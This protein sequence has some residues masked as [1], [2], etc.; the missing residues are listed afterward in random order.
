MV[1]P[2]NVAQLL[3]DLVAIPSVNP[4][5]DPGTEQTG[6][7]ALG[8]YVADFLRAL[9]AEVTLDPVEPGRPNVIA[10][11]IPDKPVAHLAFAPHL[12]TVSVAGMTIPPFDPVIRDGK[13][14]GRGSTDTKGPMAAAL[15]AV[16]AWAQSGAREK[17][18]LRLSFLA[19]MGEEAGNDGAHAL[20]RKGFSS[21]LTLVL[22]PTRLGVVTAHKGALWLEINTT[23]VACH[24]AT[25][26]QGRNAIYAMRRALEIIEEKII[27]GFSRHPHP[28]L[29]PVTLN[30]GTISGGSKINIVPDRCRAEIDCRIV[31]GI[32]TETFSRRLE[33]DLRA[34]APGVTVRLQRHSPPLETDESLPWVRR[35]GEQARGFAA[36]PW[37]SDASVLSGPQCPAIC[38]GPGSIAQAHTK[39]EFILL[40]DLEEG[41]EFFHRWM[42][43][44][45]EFSHER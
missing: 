18:R 5:G 21:D 38:I 43:A 36:A 4:Q 28:K 25:P 10:S 7:Q 20:A 14:F 29:G 41:A 40:R 2:K 3:Q 16:R 17:S 32:D 19:L 30:V 12:D 1:A 27:P 24:G 22:E 23:G 15:W 34:A 9:G 37:F 13:L 39:D 33:S 42:Q 45:E 44:A 35:L 11:F 31:P 8:E 26:D 6:E